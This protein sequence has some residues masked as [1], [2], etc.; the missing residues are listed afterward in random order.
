MLVPGSAAGNAGAGEISRD[1]EKAHRTGDGK[2]STSRRWEF[3]QEQQ[4][5]QAGISTST[6]QRCEQLAG[7]SEK[8]AMDVQMLPPN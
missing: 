3:D 6:T 8:L 2:S 7:P 1:L 5:A 4:L